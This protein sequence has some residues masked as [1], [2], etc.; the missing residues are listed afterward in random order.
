MT[1]ALPSSEIAD[2][3]VSAPLPAGEEA[4]REAC[5]LRSEMLREEVVEF[6]ERQAQQSRAERQG[7]CFS[8]E[9]T[10]AVFASF[11]FSGL[12]GQDR[13]SVFAQGA[14]PARTLEL[15]RSFDS[16]V[17]VWL[18]FECRRSGARCSSCFGVCASV[19]DGFCNCARAFF[20][21]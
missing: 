21:M 6:F 18:L 1:S 2:W 7:I 8:V 15:W 3:N 9:T 16:L 10:A 19:C 14:S 20:L 12:C 11:H 13:P 17:C 5:A 4:R